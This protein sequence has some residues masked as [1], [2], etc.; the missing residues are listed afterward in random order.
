VV[1]NIHDLG[2]TVVLVLIA[3][4]D[5]AAVIFR[6][7]VE[8]IPLLP[9]RI[10]LR[11]ARSEEAHGAIR[12]AEVVVCRHLSQQLLDSSPRLRWISYLSVGLDGKVT[13]GIRERR[14]MLT[15]S[16]G[17]HGPNIAEHI[18]T[19]ILMFT[20]RMP[21]HLRAQLAGR[22]GPHIAGGPLSTEAGEL[23]GQTLGIIG[24]GTIGTA[25]V[26][27]ARP[28]GMRIIATKRDLSQTDYPIFPDVLYPPEDL[29]S[30]LAESDHVCICVP[31]TAKTH[32]LIDAKM[33][34]QIKPG[35]YLYNISRG[36][37][38]DESALIDALTNG[39]LAGA[40]L[41]VF[42]SEPLPPDNPLWKME[43]VLITPHSAGLGSYC[44]KRAVALFADNLE[45]YLGRLTLHNL[46]DPARDY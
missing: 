23:T 22:W 7:A 46:Y 33:L 30:L 42:E 3:P 24:F 37:V 34:S 20:H 11:F 32:H 2:K 28:L 40:G 39:R 43:N 1:D 13:P 10:E 9:E 17:A 21:Q 31:Y 36:G 27:R 15:T 8:R 6:D 19:F 44:F 18:L 26:A 29:S 25:L 14:I 41:D 5:I 16:K 45:R 12:D 38:V 4:D 35:S